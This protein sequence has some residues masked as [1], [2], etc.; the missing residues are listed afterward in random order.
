MIIISDYMEKNR[1]TNDE[2]IKRLE[3][4]IDNVIDR[5]ITFNDAMDKAMSSR[6]SQKV[7]DTFTEKSALIR[8]R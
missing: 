8:F 1:M 6:D 7:I 3:D 5:S 4:V 2:Y